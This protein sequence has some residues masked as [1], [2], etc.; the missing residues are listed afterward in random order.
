MVS[1]MLQLVV[2]LSLD[3]LD[4]VVCAGV[5]HE[6]SS[7]SESLESHCNHTRLLQISFLPKG[8]N[9]LEFTTT[10]NSHYQRTTA[11]QISVGQYFHKTRPFVAETACNDDGTNAIYA[12]AYNRRR[13]YAYRRFTSQTLETSL[14]N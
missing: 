11:I 14:R 10:Q 9:S 2:G 13:E 3:C 4:W 7:R 6:N 5:S 12:H 8:N 1:F